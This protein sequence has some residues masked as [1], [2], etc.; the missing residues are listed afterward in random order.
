MR[1]IIGKRHA[2]LT[3]TVEVKVTIFLSTSLQ[4]VMIFSSHRNST[5]PLCKY[6]LK[7]VCDF[8]SGYIGLIN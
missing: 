3:V 1:Y 4:D 6:D 2:V 7:Y 5:Y 8:L